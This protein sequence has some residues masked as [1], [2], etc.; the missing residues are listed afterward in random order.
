MPIGQF[1]SVEIDADQ[2]RCN[3]V[4]L[5]RGPQRLLSGHI[6]PAGVGADN[7]IRSICVHSYA[8]RHL[9]Q[10]RLPLQL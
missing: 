10:L 6:L 7:S 1:R 8:K 4:M 2:S 5:F 9:F 3:A